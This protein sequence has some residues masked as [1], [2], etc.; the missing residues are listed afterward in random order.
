MFIVPIGLINYSPL[1]NI[2]LPHYQLPIFLNLLKREPLNI[3]D[4]KMNGLGSTFKINGSYFLR[5]SN[6]E[7]R[8]CNFGSRVP[9]V[10]ASSGSRLFFQ[11]AIKLERRF[12]LAPLFIFAR[13]CRLEDRTMQRASQKS[14]NES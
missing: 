12:N 2:I 11:R 3:V 9:I 6:F 8:V 14:G 4:S 5:R 1:K 13:S 7:H 10:L